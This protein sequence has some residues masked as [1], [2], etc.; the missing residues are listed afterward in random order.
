MEALIWVLLGAG[1]VVAEVL[2]L[3]LVLGM[4]GV[5]ALLTGGVAAL[6]APIEV[7]ALTFLISSVALILLVRPVAKRSIRSNPEADRTEA[8]ALAGQQA[9]VTVPIDDNSGQVRINGELW[10]ARAYAGGPPL[11]VGEVVV[12]AETDGAT[13]MVYPES[14]GE[15]YSST[16]AFYLKTDDDPTPT[17][18]ETETK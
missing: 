10:R 6:G 7:Q 18:T 13:L 15:P 3:T 5:A 4:I 1:L 16:N 17:E 12:V 14:L 11:A 8:R 2:T 9:L